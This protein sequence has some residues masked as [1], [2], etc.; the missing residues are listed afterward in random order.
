MWKLIEMGGWHA[1]SKVMSRVV[2]PY[3]VIVNS[4]ASP[5]TLRVI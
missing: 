5:V 2:I 4:S 1:A 3:L